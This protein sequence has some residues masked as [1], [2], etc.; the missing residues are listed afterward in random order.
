MLR[1]DLGGS[2]APKNEG[3]M[4]PVKRRPPRRGYEQGANSSIEAPR[5][6]L[7]GHMAFYLCVKGW[8]YREEGSWGNFPFRQR[9]L[10]GD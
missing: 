10:L 5:L 7:V 3:D 2:L 9:N 8:D 1:A 4:D 6:G